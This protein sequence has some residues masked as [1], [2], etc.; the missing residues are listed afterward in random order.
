V[1]ELPTGTLAFLLTDIEGSTRLW[2]RQ[3]AVMREASARHDRIIEDLVAEHGGDVVRPRGEGDSRFAVFR[4]AVGA[5]RAASSIQL[6]L[7]AE[8]WPTSDPLRVRMAVHTGDAD[9]REGDYYGTAPSRCA[10]LRSLAHGGQ[11]LVSAATAA[12]AQES[13]DDGIALRDLGMHRL[14]DLT[15]PEHIFQLLHPELPNDFAPLRSL[16]VLPTNLPVQVTSFIGREPELAEVKRLLAATRLLTLTGAGGS[17]KTRLALQAAADLVETYQDGIWSVDLASLAEPGL[18][19]HAVAAVVGV[20]EESD[21][22]LGETLAS[23]L[24]AREL[25]LV[26]DNCEHLIVACAQLVDGLVHA[27]PKLRILTTSREP[28]GIAGE[29][30]WRVPPLRLADPQKLPSFENL[31]QYEAVRLF[32]DRALGVQPRFSVTNQNA[33]A[34]AQICYRLDGIPLAI[35]LA[36]ARVSVLAVDEIARRLDDRFHLLTRGSRTALR[37]QQT[38]RALVD[39]SHDLLSAEEQVLFRRLGV[40]AGGWTLDAAESVCSAKPIEPP[41]VLDLLSRLVDKSLVLAEEQSDGSMRYRLLETLR[42][43]ATERLQLAD[44]SE[45]TLLAH[46]TYYLGQTALVDGY[47]WA[48]N[49][50]EWARVGWPWFT[51]ELD[52]LR[53]VLGR[54]RDGIVGPDRTLQISLRMCHGLWWLWSVFGQYQESWDWHQAILAAS[55]FR[56]DA[57]YAWALWGSGIVGTMLSRFDK[58]EPQLR[59]ALQIARELGDAP[60]MAAAVGGLGEDFMHQGRLDE[61]RP[62]LEQSLDEVRTYGP[63]C[64]LPIVYQN[65]ARLALIQGRLEDAA[66]LLDESIAAARSMNFRVLL[67]LVLTLRGMVYLARGKLDAAEELF[68]EAYAGIQGLPPGSL[69]LAALGLG[70][71][72]L[73]RGDL[74]EAASRFSWMLDRARA[75]GFRMGTCETLSGIAFVAAARAQFQ[76]AIQLFGAVDRLR[77]ELKTPLQPDDAQRTEAALQALQSSVGEENFEAAWHKGR[78]MDLYEAMDFGKSLSSKT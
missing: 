11:V 29:T 6:A 72:A 33:P 69:N 2:E 13:L 42:E 10:R 36:A 19:A 37:R 48:A 77:T 70:Q 22:P 8:Q 51:V 75:T 67:E 68:N 5:V 54:C 31:T 16:N 20:H 30:T 15:I 14:R 53:A 56:L 25:L 40:F 34:V 39:W 27:C 65:P 47:R 24:H 12:L 59:Q 74:E 58:S 52:N 43:Y 50:G 23:A 18:V 62:L 71:I 73:L 9:L 41:A 61:A 45:A 44:E 78:A 35:E 76:N 63:K 64:Y 38:L 4:S 49:W 66:T 46:A 32:I 1:A 21:R 26:L 3:P 57:A 28:L 7:Q 17:G 55:P 60:L